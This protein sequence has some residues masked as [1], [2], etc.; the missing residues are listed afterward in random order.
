[1]STPGSRRTARRRARTRGGKGWDG[2]FEPLDVAW[3]PA[4]NHRR[5]LALGGTQADANLVKM[6]MRVHAMRQDTF[7]VYGKDDA[8][9][10]RIKRLL[11]A[12]VSAACLALGLCIFCAHARPFAILAPRNLSVH[13]RHLHA[14]NSRPPPFSR[15]L[16]TSKI[17]KA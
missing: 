7:P 12:N 13:Q 9:K 1:M 14:H 4:C 2:Y 11:R 17:S 5:R 15:S 16:T 8:T 10:Q 3:P 6:A